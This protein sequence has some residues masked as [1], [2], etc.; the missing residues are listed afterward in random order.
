MELPAADRREYVLRACGGDKGLER[1]VLDLLAAH[2]DAGQFMANPTVIAAAQAESMVEQP[3]D[4]VGPY[5]LLAVAGVGGFGTVWLAERREPYVQRVALKIINPGMDS[6]VVIARFEQE[7]Q[8]LAVMDHPNVAKVLDGGLTT[9]GRPYFVM[10]YVKGE[11]ITEFCDKHRLTIHQRLEM[12]IPVCE[13]VQHA[14]MKGIIHRD[15]KPS[16]ILVSIVDTGAAVEGGG[17]GGSG[18]EGASPPGG[19]QAS[20]RGALVKV[21]DFGIA[22]AI[23][24]TLTDKTIFTE[25]GEVMGTPEYMSPEQ[26]EMGAVDVDTRTDVY[27]LGMVLYELL[28]GVLPFDPAELRSKGYNEMQRILREVEITPPI[29]RVR[30]LAK[31]RECRDTVRR[32]CRARNLDG[33]RTLGRQVGKEVQL[34]VMK[35]L[36]KDRVR[37]YE[38]ALSLGRD[39]Q[40]ALLGE[41]IQAR[42]ESDWYRLRKFLPLGFKT[43]AQ[44]FAGGGLLFLAVAL[45][46]RGLAPAVRSALVIQAFGMCIAVPLKAWFFQVAARMVARVHVPFAWGYWLGIGAGLMVFV[47]AQLSMSVLHSARTTAQEAAAIQFLVGVPVAVLFFIGVTFVMWLRFGAGFWRSALTALTAVAIDTVMAVVSI[48]VALGMR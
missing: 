5:K 8:A 14:H 40:N 23:S 15:I 2:E 33:P 39:V 30:T 18:G 48:A 46:D 21:I 44:A 42:R 20:V 3:G 27:S 1:K 22:K 6:R 12:F 7:R 17:P 26:A 19:P 16:N 24:H 31:V 43:V 41:P 4:V 34:I 11:P 38:T 13:A 47:W 36:A 9:L 25:R 45:L 32:L 37:R 28:T 29:E 35:A 10:E